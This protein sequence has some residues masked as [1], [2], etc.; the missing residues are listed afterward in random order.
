MLIH[1]RRSNLYS[2]PSATFV[3]RCIL[4]GASIIARLEA[5]ASAL[6]DVDVEAVSKSNMS[7]P[8]LHASV[9]HQYKILQSL[10]FVSCASLSRLLTL[11]FTSLRPPQPSRH[12]IHRVRAVQQPVRRWLPHA[13]LTLS[14]TH[15]WR[16]PYGV[17]IRRPGI[18]RRVRNSKWPSLAPEFV[19]VLTRP[20]QNYATGGYPVYT[21]QRTVSQ[22]GRGERSYT[23]VCASTYANALACSVRRLRPPRPLLC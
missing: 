12:G 22:Y 23:T 20:K 3:C 5:S 19:T 10:P 21:P 15:V 17:R 16:P 8:S 4:R 2:K 6:R 14:W 1:H 13:A 9:S 11:V 7:C 18:W